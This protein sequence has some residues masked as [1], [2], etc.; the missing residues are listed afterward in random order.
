MLA[1]HAPI[2]RYDSAESW[3]AESVSPF[4][5]GLS[6]PGGR[7]DHVSL[8]PTGER[9][10]HNG[11]S[12]PGGDRVYGHAARGSDG[13]VW[14]AY[15]FFYLANDPRLLGRWLPAG[16]HEGDWEMIQLRLDP[17]GAVP[18][19]A[20]YAQHHHVGARRWEAVERDGSG[21]RPV[22]YVARGSHACYF[23]AGTHWTGV[24]FE[25]AD[26]Y[27][28]R[29]A[30]PLEVIADDEATSNWA[31]WPGH[32]GTTEARTGVLARLGLAAASPR[33]PGHQRQWR[34]PAVLM[35]SAP[36][37]LRAAP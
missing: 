16:V 7:A 12:E 37:A 30:P 17:A 25:R 24:W 13:R 2:L 15:W 31:R 23:D 32:W 35:A 5:G 3:Y 1:R 34:D 36:G 4:V 9:P 28:R 27:G 10:Q 22:I 11:L 18:N 14:L 8:A 33:G 6:R 26:G 21:D 20:L 19:L 29:L